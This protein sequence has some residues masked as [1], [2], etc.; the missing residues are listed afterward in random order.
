M[1]FRQYRSL[2][3]NSEE[4]FMLHHATGAELSV[5]G[6]DPLQVEEFVGQIITIVFVLPT[7]VLGCAR[8]ARLCLSAMACGVGACRI[9]H[10]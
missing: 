5:D 6:V 4:K 8:A 9:G 3:V 1:K 10:D 7:E 2:A